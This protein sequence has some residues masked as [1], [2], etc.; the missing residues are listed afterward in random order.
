MYI[1]GKKV[2]EYYKKNG[3]VEYRFVKLLLVGPPQVGKTTTKDKLIG[4][5]NNLENDP[6]YEKRTST[7]VEKPVE[8]TV[9]YKEEK[10]SKEGGPVEEQKHTMPHC[11][12]INH[13]WPQKPLDIDESFQ[14][15]LHHL[16]QK[17]NA[18]LE[19]PT[20]TIGSDTPIKPPL[21]KD[22]TPTPIEDVSFIDRYISTRDLDRC[23]VVS[24][25][26]S[27]P[28]CIYMIDTG[29]QPEIQDIVPLLLR[30]AAFYLLFFNV[31]ESLDEHYTIKCTSKS[32]TSIY[33]SPYTVL[34]V[35]SQHLN[36]ILYHYKSEK[37]ES[38]LK[39]S[40]FIL[41]T[42]CDLPQVTEDFL[43]DV[44]EKIEENFQTK[45]NELYSIIY[46]IPKSPYLFMPVN[47]KKGTCEEIEKLGN[48]ITEAVAECCKPYS[49]PIVILMFHLILRKE[50]KAKKVYSFEDSVELAGKCGIHRDD[51]GKILWY[52]YRTFGTIL[53]V[54]SK[55]N[56]YLSEVVI[57]D[58]EIIFKSISKLIFRVYEH[59]GYD[60]H[61][62]GE[63]GNTVFENALCDTLQWECMSPLIDAK[64][65]VELV[66]HFK[67][68]TILK[69]GESQLKKTDK[70]LNSS[71]YGNSDSVYFMPCLLRPN[72]NVALQPSKTDIEKYP[73]VIRFVENI[74][75]IGLVP[76]LAVELHRLWRLNADCRY[77][78]HLQLKVAYED[79]YVSVDL[80][81]R[82]S[83]LELVCEDTAPDGMRYQLL[84]D[85]KQAINNLHEHF[86][87]RED[88]VFYQLYCPVNVGGFAEFDESKNKKYMLC[89]C[90]GCNQKN[91]KIH[92]KQRQ[93]FKVKCDYKDIL[94]KEPDK[95]D[96]LGLLTQISHQWRK[97]GEK[98]L[99]HNSNHLKSIK[100]AYSDD[101]ERLSETIDYWMRTKST[102][103]TW[104]TVINTLCSKF[105][106]EIRVADDIKEQ[107][108]TKLY[109]KYMYSQK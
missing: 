62:H 80:I 87:Y 106:Q 16:E 1:I 60:M 43:K 3:T 95:D 101:R 6:D 37:D 72:H 36:T 66:Q 54:K 96:L 23:R 52:M 93:W 46:N 18:T 89:E 22:F 81:V 31:A 5:I 9:T 38:G 40:S 104:D 50:F 28:A 102:L 90:T 51:V 24:E 14:V 103:V 61:T 27:I 20:H 2:I 42:H 25:F 45:F 11:I 84:Q 69:T 48:V 59:V 75:P 26:E 32:S 15:L 12:T 53:Y 17:A 21:L 97:I 44:N 78:N 105:V 8:I 85:I 92:A 35:L 77:K 4:A 99:K 33:K 58:P 83:H 34:Q 19:P 57:C 91:H 47:N 29:G 67:I 74:V 64:Y 10:E 65:V 94:E 39:P 7:G 109:D 41:G 107:L 79:E 88:S 63:I 70:L 86:G 100:K 30:G 68:I 98:L 82:L 71:I 49:V 55:D 73:L 13:K 108:S 76:A 56:Q